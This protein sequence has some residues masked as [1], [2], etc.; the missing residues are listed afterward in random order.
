M[1]YPWKDEAAEVGEGVGADRVEEEVFVF[2]AEV[3]KRFAK[4][5]PFHQ[6][7]EPFQLLDLALLQ[8]I[9]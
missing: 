4:I 1:A 8:L 7:G 5:W 3:L 9:P 2:L 6:L